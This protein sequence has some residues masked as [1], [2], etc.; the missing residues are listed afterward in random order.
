MICVL[1][2]LL[3]PVC[4]YLLFQNMFR[5]SR[6]VT[7]VIDMIRP[8]DEHAFDDLLNKTKE[9]ILRANSSATAFKREQRARAWLLFEYLRRMA[10]NAVVILSWT[11]AE[12]EKLRRPGMSKDESRTGIINDLV[13]AGPAFRLYALIALSKLSWR[14]LLDGLKITPIR[15]ITDLRRAEDSDGLDAYRRLANAAAALS[16]THGADA[17]RQLVALLRGGDF[18]S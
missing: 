13:D 8:V 9:D 4:S 11:Y 6:S 14:I 12:Q 7:D 5:F 16:A 17:H 3:V 10:F 1:L 15:T 18:V 2:L